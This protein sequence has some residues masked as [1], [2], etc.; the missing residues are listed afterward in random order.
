MPQIP[1]AIT[2]LDNAYKALSAFE[3]VTTGAATIATLE[4]AYN[5]IEVDKAADLNYQDNELYEYFQYDEARK[6]ARD[7]INSTT[8]P[9]VPE[10]YIEGE[11]LS[12]A[13]IEA[14]ANANSG[15]IKTGINATVSAP[16]QDAMNKYN[17][18]VANFVAP[19][20]SELQLEDQIARLSYYYAF[21]NA[22]KKTTTVK[23]FLNQEI[24]I[25][26]A[27]NYVQGD[28]SADSWAAYTKALADAK[29][30]QADAKALQSAVFDAKYELM[31]AQNE[32]LPKYASMKDN[33]YLDGELATLIEQANTVVGHFNEYF[34]VKDGVDATEAWKQLVKALGV[35]YNVKVDGTDYTGILYNHSALTF[36]AYD[37][38]NSNKEKAK[39]DA[40]CDKLQAALN[41]FV[42]S[43]TL[44]TNNSGVVNQVTQDVRYIQGIVPGTVTTADAILNNVKA[45]NPA[46]KLAVTPSKSNGFGTGATVKVSVDG[47]GVLTSYYVVVYGDVN[48]DGVVDAFDAFAVDKNVNSLAALDGVYAKAADADASG[49]I[50]VADLTPIMS[51]SVG[52][53][54]VISQTR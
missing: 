15:N 22:T 11:N 13:V 33:G 8:A 16:S 49:A 4:N 38:L 23:D 53:V 48:G 30:V 3:K 10:N 26:E 46:A 2:A 54:D 9:T 51:A 42:S 21:M 27:Q 6:A 37:R 31:K 1:D 29:A 19:K 44:D 40:A 25:A 52:N 41:N 20:Y 36:K 43:V 45:S 47:I 12:Q 39:V 32:L 18:A 7:M 50:T 17:D 34:K 24:S 28:Y 5:A 35:E 14:I